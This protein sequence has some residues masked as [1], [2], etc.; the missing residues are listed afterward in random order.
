MAMGGLHKYY[1]YILTN[2]TRTVLY[3][4]VSNNIKQRLTQHIAD[5]IGPRRTFAGKYNCIHIV[6]YEVWQ[7]VQEA[8]RR[9]TEIKGWSRDKKLALIRK[10]NPDLRF[11]D[12]DE[13]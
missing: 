6:Y 12:D 13:F 9:E 5:A 10:E 11:L 3:I 8:I 2:P 4:G 1:T 7:W